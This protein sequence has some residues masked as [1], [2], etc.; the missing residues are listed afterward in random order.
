MPYQSTKDLPDSVTNVLPIN[1]QRI[2]MNVY[3]S[4]EERGDS[5]ED[6]IKQ[7][8]GAVGKSYEKVDGEWVKKMSD[9]FI[10]FSDLGD[11]WYLLFPTRKVWHRG[12]EINFTK[13]K[14]EAAVNNFKIDN[15]PGYP[16]PINELHTDSTGTYG[17]ISDMRVTD[18]GLEWKPKWRDGKLE[19]A[20]KK[21][22]SFISPEVVFSGY[23]HTYTGKKY[24]TPVFVG[25]ALTPRPRLGVATAIFSDGK[26]EY[27][28]EESLFEGIKSKVD[29][30]WSF[31]QGEEGYELMAEK[32]E[33]GEKYSKDAY[34]ITPDADKPS[35]WKVRVESEPGEVTVKQL[36][37]AAAALHSYSPGVTYRGKSLTGVTDEQ[38]A[39]AKKKL[40]KLYKE[41]GVD[42]EEIPEYLFSDRRVDMAEEHDKNLLEQILEKLEVKEEDKVDFSAELESFGEQLRAE[43]AE[44]LEAKDAEITELQ[45][46][47]ELAESEAKELSEKFA[48]E[49]RKHR[50]TEF[51]DRAGEL[52]V[53]V[54]ASE[55]GEV[56]MHFHDSDDSEDK[57]R[58]SQL[59]TVLESAKYAD[60]LFEEMGSGG[61]I[62][63]PVK[64]FEALVQERVDNGDSYSDATLSVAS[65]RPDLYKEYDALTTKVAEGD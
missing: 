47:K 50:L 28:V 46:A 59:I 39:A 37:H 18:R 24:D 9:Y 33:D 12:R 1:A 53:P 21:G 29:Q 63:D 51:A 65:E 8:W 32:T 56:L 25:A 14:A 19:E 30:L 6:A 45:E 7:A 15:V 4:A 40:V 48:E 20:R 49:E 17:V 52:D 55:F 2:W 58:Y 54:D 36:G 57:A 38:V 23:Q 64:K 41:Q 44:K 31:F 16:P 5:E 60:E 22:F 3:N 26:W 35:T 13:E 43:F 10:P 61:D 11:N 42:E 34:L 27:V 62:G